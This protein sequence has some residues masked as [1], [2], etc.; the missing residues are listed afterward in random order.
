[1]SFAAGDLA[2]QSTLHADPPACSMER[3]TRFNTRFVECI[4]AWTKERAA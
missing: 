4:A 2:D 1:M 3:P